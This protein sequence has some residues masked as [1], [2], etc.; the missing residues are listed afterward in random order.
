[1]KITK[2]I[3]LPIYYVGDKFRIIKDATS[4][5]HI[6]GVRFVKK[7]G[8]LRTMAFRKGVVRV[9]GNRPEVTAKTNIT[10]MSNGMMKVFD[11]GKVGYRTVNLKTVD[12]IRADGIRY[13]FT[14]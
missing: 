2:T 14:A 11:M 6:V 10:L 1:M 9:N 12:V 5:G 8:Q 7:N 3:K 4:K 13:E